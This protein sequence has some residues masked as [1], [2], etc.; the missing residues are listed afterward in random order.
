MIVVDAPP[1]HI[2]LADAGAVLRRW[3]WPADLDDVHRAIEDSREHLRPFMPW[4]DQSVDGT[5]Q[6][7]AKTDEQWGAGTDYTYAIVD[8]T[9]G[10]VL[11]GCGLHTR[12]GPGVLE[13][14]YWLRADA[15]GRGL[16][17]A[18]AGALTD[19]AMAVDGVERVEIWCDEGNADSAAIPRRLGYRLDRMEEVPAEAPGGRG[20][21]MVWVFPA[22]H[23]ANGPRSEVV[24]TH[25]D[26][27]EPHV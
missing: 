24:A 10:T 17:T 3:R 2:T 4:A 13:I 25:G 20:R 7:L 21:H 8:A 16:A 22:G 23:A 15:T 26:Q 1:E 14:G 27:R 9:T 11:G 19:G 12:R 6:F 5:A 18:A